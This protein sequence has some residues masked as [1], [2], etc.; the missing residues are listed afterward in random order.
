MVDKELLALATKAVQMYSESHPRPVQVTQQ[1]AAEMLGISR[2]T[3]AKLIRSGAI[4]LNK[5]GLITV[6]D[7]DALLA[8]N[9]YK[10]TTE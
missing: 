4:K 6:T 9:Y 7:V 2:H 1:Q 5:C 10:P 8:I 3:V